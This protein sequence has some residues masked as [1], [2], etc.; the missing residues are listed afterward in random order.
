ML[1][2][3]VEELNPELGDHNF[4][5]F[6]QK[7]PVMIFTETSKEDTSKINIEGYWNYCQIRP[8]QKNAISNTSKI[9]ILAKHIITSGIKFIE[10]TKTIYLPQKIIEINS[11]FYGK[12]RAKE[13]V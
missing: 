7:H 5:D 12:W 1:F 9:T 2:F 3:N 6:I 4:T 10:N 13:K 11:T 8:K